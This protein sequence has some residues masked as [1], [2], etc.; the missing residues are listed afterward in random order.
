MGEIIKLPAELGGFIRS[1]DAPFS[2]YVAPAFHAGFELRGKGVQLGAELVVDP[3]I[4][5][6][7]ASHAHSDEHNSP[8]ARGESS[9]SPKEHSAKMLLRQTFG[10]LAGGFSTTQ[11]PGEFLNQLFALHPVHL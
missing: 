8:T 1:S 4:F 2:D 3:P 5:D 10:V 11:H 7:C 6:V 9:G